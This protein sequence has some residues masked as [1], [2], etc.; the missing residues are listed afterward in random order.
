MATAG[1]A[2]ALTAR[3]PERSLSE[4]RASERT[5]CCR[6]RAAMTERE[7]TFGSS[8]HASEEE[9]GSRAPRYACA[10]KTAFLFNSLFFCVLIPGVIYCLDKPK[11][12]TVNLNL[13]DKIIIII[14]LPKS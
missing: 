11:Y 13:Y 7:V 4:G 6:T 3:L 10:Q 1:P 9:A 2:A 5:H 14:N 8:Q 12:T